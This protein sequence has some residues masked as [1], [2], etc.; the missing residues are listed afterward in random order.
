MKLVKPMLLGYQEEVSSEDGWL[1]EPKY[2]GF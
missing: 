2:N 1:Y